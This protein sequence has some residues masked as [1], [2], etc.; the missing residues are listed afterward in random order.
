MKEDKNE[1]ND[2]IEIVEKVDNTL[3][4]V[5]VISRVIRFFFKSLFKF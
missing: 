2:E 5:Y 3:T 4:T 1:N